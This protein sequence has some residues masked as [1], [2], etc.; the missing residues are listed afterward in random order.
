MPSSKGKRTSVRMILGFI[1]V[2]MVQKSKPVE[3]GN[4]AWG[5]W[6]PASFSDVVKLNAHLIESWKK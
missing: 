2:V 4:W 6:W 3:G 1:P 5:R